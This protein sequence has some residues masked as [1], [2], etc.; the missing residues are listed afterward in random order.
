MTQTRLWS[1]RQMEAG[2]QKR[3]LVAAQDLF[4]QH[5]FKRVSIDEI[6]KKA[7]VAKGT[8]YNFAESKDELYFKV[9]DE[10]LRTW[11]HECGS[12]IDETKPADEL[13]I[14]TGLYSYNYLDTKP[15]LRQLLTDDLDY[16]LKMWVEKLDHIRKMCA[17]NCARILSLGIQQGKFRDDLDVNQAALV[18]N[19]IMVQGLIMKYKRGASESMLWAATA[20]DLVLRGL[21]K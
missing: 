13:M 10:E 14:S 15:T 8:V 20:M 9:V 16:S 5:G 11:V 17:Q 1:I 21:Q 3:I 2:K 6:A 4:G 18:L 12:R 7:G 19:D